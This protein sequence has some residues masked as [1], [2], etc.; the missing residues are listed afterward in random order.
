MG[1]EPSKTTHDDPFWSKFGQD[2][3]LRAMASRSVTK[4]VGSQ[5]F[6][7]NARRT[8][9]ERGQVRL[10]GLEARLNIERECESC[11]NR[12]KPIRPNQKF[13][14]QRCAR[15]VRFARYVQRKALGPAEDS[16]RAPQA[17]GANRQV[18]ALEIEA[19]LPADPR[20]IFLIS[21]P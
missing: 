2:F 5:K 7:C 17:D 13:C 20:L 12:F 21:D 6:N 4:W 16:E 14:S 18:C 11:Q 19:A 1:L 9:T 15:K 3:I 10:L 8:P